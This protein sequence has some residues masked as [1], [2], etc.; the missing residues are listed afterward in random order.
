MNRPEFNKVP[1]NITLAF[2]MNW[3]D[4]IKKLSDVKMNNQ[5]VN[6]PVKLYLRPDFEQGLKANECTLT[7]LKTAL[8][9]VFTIA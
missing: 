9:R 8:P 4:T 7:E 3:R 2:P 5:L 6:L 1:D